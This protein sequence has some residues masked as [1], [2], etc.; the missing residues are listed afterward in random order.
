MIRRVPSFSRRLGAQGDVW[1]GQKDM[2]LAFL[3]ATLTMLIV[4]LI[5]WHYDPEFSTD[6]RQPED[7]AW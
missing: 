6:L 5:N 2:L 3:G 7:R 1:D 4:A